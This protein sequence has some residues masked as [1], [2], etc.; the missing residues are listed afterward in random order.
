MKKLTRR[1]K[2]IVLRAA[3]LV[4]SSEVVYCCDALRIAGD[5]DELL[6]E[7]FGDFYEMSI[8]ISW[9]E[10]LCSDRVAFESWAIEWRH[11]VD[12]RVLCLLT[13]AELG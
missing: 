11:I 4:A 12:A 7:R 5:H 10:H 6:P 2:Q 3:E 1:E 8:G 9:S 13:F